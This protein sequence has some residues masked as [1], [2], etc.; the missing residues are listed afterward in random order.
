MH[1]PILKSS[2]KLWLE[3][4]VGMRIHSNVN[5][6]LYLFLELNFN[7]WTANWFDSNSSIYCQIEQEV[8]HGSIGFIKFLAWCSLPPLKVSWPSFI[9]KVVV[10]N[11]FLAPSSCFFE[12]SKVLFP[13]GPTNACNRISLCRLISCCMKCKPQTEPHCVWHFI[14]RVFFNIL[15]S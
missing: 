5:L 13:P 8:T 15:S 3:A 10:K 9:V 12:I 6:K 2:Y 11:S 4:W 1:L 14:C 7:L